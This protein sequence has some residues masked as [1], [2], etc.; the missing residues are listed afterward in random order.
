MV[1][2]WLP[3][4]WRGHLDI[5][6]YYLVQETN[7]RTASIQHSPTVKFVDNLHDSDLRGHKTVVTHLRSQ[8]TEQ[9]NCVV[10]LHY[11]QI[12]LCRILPVSIPDGLL[13]LRVLVQN[14]ACLLMSHD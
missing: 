1:Q 14:S 5:T 2:M 3:R 10:F 9:D 11:F 13:D 6:D 8:S 4:C 12:G 7:N